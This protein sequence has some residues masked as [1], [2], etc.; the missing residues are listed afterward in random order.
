MRGEEQKRKWRS[1]HTSLVPRP[2]LISLH[3][4]EI[5]CESG[6]GMGIRLHVLVKFLT[7]A[8]KSMS[9]RV[10]KSEIGGPGWVCYIV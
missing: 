5:K 2:L 3:E 4:F 10:S 9:S 7:T 8:L 6:L 1:W